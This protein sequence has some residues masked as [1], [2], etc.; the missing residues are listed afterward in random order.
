MSWAV[1]APGGGM[2]LV[3]EKGD[4]GA[5]KGADGTLTRVAPD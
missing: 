4:A 3:M 1:M 2:A 5:G